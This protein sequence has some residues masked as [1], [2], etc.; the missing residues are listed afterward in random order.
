MDVERRLR[1]GAQ[2]SP[3]VWVVY[4]DSPSRIFLTGKVRSHRVHFKIESFKEARMKISID[5]VLASRTKAAWAKLTPAI[6]A[7]LQPA[8][9]QAHQQAIAVSQT[10][11]APGAPAAPHHL[12]LA[13]SVLNDDQD[14][15]LSSLEAGIVFDVDRDGVIWGTGKYEQLDP[16]WIEAFASFL[17]TLLLGKHP[18]M[19]IPATISIPDNVKIGLAGDWGTGNWRTGANPAPSTNVC[20]QLQNL[21][22]D[23]TIHLGDVYYAGSSD[24]EQHELTM[25]WPKGSIGSLA[26]NSNHEM[27]SGAKPYFQAL[28][29]SPFGMQNGCSY[30]VMENANWVIVGLDSAYFAPE[31]EMYINGSL[32]PTTLSTQVTFLQ[33]QVAKGKKVIVLTHHNGLKEDASGPMGLLA[34]VMSGF[35]SGGG[36]AL[37]YW[38]HMHAGIV[39][40]PYG[41]D[42]ISLRCC[43]HGGLPWGH[44]SALAN[45]PQ[46]IWYEHQPAGDPDIPQRVCNG[47]AVLSLDGPDVHEA[48]YN[49]KGEIEWQSA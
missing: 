38:G 12:M 28:A 36:P 32:G 40:A 44:A 26:L 8:I 20:T 27:Y 4:D 15:V 24:Q 2:Y 19:A 37:W 16:G 25:L 3:F 35:P 39:Y 1:A 47:F 46:V 11:Q 49:E 21:Q 6:Q 42:K 31:I 23:L 34:E 48:F 10:K 18:F 45:N 29:A 43:G 30:F 7:Q 5:P 41:P 33:D 13:Q 9:T 22:L 14:N 17:E